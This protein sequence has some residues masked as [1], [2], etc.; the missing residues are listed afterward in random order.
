[1]YVHIS[2]VY[3]FIIAN[4]G[5]THS[6]SHQLGSAALVIHKVHTPV[7][8]RHEC[9]A[10]INTSARTAQAHPAHKP[11]N[12]LIS[13]PAQETRAFQMISPLPQEFLPSSAHAD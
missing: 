10:M 5:E 6:H 12:E 11:A 8:L 2:I 7:R 13:A 3:T 9:L 4:P 1:M